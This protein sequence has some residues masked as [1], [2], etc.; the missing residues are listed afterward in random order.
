MENLIDDNKLKKFNLPVEGMTCASC[1]ARVEKAIGKIEGVKSV[2]VNIATEKASFE[3][4]TSK[5]DLNKIAEAVEDA[6]YKMPLPVLGE[7]PSADQPKTEED[8]SFNQYYKSLTKDL[9][10]ALTLTIPVFLVSMSMEF[11]WF[12]KLFP[13]AL[14][15][16]KLM[17]YINKLLLI[18]T[19]PIVFISGKRFF[20][21]FWNNLKHLAADM[22]SLVAIGT[23][24]AYLYSLIATLFPELVVSSG[25]TP[26]VYYDS[27]AVIITLILLGRWLEN[28]AKQ[29]TGSAIKK[30]IELKPKTASVLKNGSELKVKL[31]DLALNDIVVVRPGEKIPADGVITEGYSTV[32]ESMITGESIPVEKKL[33]SRVTGGTINKTGSFNFRIT[34]LGNNSVLGQ[35]IRLVEEAQGSKAPIQK[36]A[37]KI[38]SVFVPVVVAIAFITFLAWLIIGGDNAFNFALVNFVAVLIIACPCALGLATPTAIMVGTGLGANHGILIKNGESLEEAHKISTIILDKTGTITEGKPAVTDIVAH[39]ISENELL[40]IAA[41]AENKSEHPLAL[42]I[43]ESAKSRAIELKNVEV[44]QSFTGH[45]ISAVINGGDAVAIGN[46]KLMADYS[47]KTDR[48]NETSGKLSAEGKTVIYIAV[49]GELKGL[50]AIEDPVKDSSLQAIAELK[51]MNI[52]VVM[53]TGDNQKT[54]QAIADRVG[55]NNFSAGILPHDKANEIKKYQTNGTVVAMVGDGIND[56]PALAQSNVGIAMG[57]GTDVAIE[58]AD[59]TLLKGD[60]KGVVSAIKLSRRTIRTIKQNL[61]WAFIYNVLGIPLAA[62]GL[63]NPMFAAL[64]MSFSSVSVVSNSL[65]LRAVKLK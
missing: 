29:K 22:N 45:G 27:T 10:F 57:T 30:L 9:I 64:A 24:T 35:I 12:H 34:A 26:H 49:N 36:L 31:E 59:I 63:L 14:S 32:D 28:R 11:T 51:K 5:V 39:G 65:R 1:V 41:S 25:K 15:H 44:F 53:L 61:F 42:A 58:T 48:F 7:L 3:I 8:S 54:A 47:L 2:A 4:D 23:G 18:F 6:G 13:S 52:N 46:D 55:I 43:V 60:L 37:D 56:A 17:D 40:R 62:F 19:T 33:N 21:I 38:A 50:L 20:V 16:M